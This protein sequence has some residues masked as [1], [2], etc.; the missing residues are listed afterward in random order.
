[1]T[2]G[3][4][5]NLLDK[6]SGEFKAY[7]HKDNDPAS[8]PNN[9]I[10]AL[11]VDRRGNVWVGTYLG[12]VSKMLSVPGTFE[13]YRH[14]S[15][16]S[17]TVSEL[18]VSAVYEDRKGNLWVGTWAGGLNLFNWETKKFKHYQYHKNDTT[19]INSNWIVDVFEDTRGQ[20]WVS[21]NEGCNQLDTK[22][23][24]FI[25]YKFFD[26]VKKAYI[27]FFC[28]SVAE[29][30]QGNLWLGTNL[31]LKH[32]D[33]TTKVY[34]TYSTKQGLANEVVSGLLADDKGNL[35]LTTNK[36]LSK[37][38]TRTK[39]F[40]NFSIDDGLQGSDFITHAYCKTSKGEMIFGGNNGFN[41]FHPDSIKDNAYIPP[42]FI[43]DLLI[44]NKPVSLSS[45]DSPLEK[46][47]S[48]TKELVLSYKQSVFT[49][50]FTALNYIF[51]ANNQY[52]Y[53]MEGFDKDWNY[54]GNKRAAT[55]TNL[56]PGTYTFRVKASN[57]DGLWN[58]QGT[59]IQ[60]TI[61]PPFWQ[62]WWFRCLLTFIIIGGA[63]SFYLYRIN[64]IK[65]QKVEL[66]N[67]VL[68]R[69]AEVMMQKEEL[70]AQTDFLQFINEELEEQKEEI[71]SEREAAD[72]ARQ[73][74]EQA[75]Q[76]KSIF[77]ST[78]SHEI[79]TPMNG[80]IGMASLLLETPLNTEQREYADTI[81]NCGESL[82]G[83]IN[84][85]LDFSK[86]ESGK[87]ELE[88]H[89]FD[90]R[91]CLE[92]VLDLFAA[93][94]ALIGLDLVYQM[95]HQV[96][97][98]IIGDSLRLRQIL[99]NLVGNAIKFTKQGEIFVHVES[100]PLPDSTDLELT[101]HIRDTGIGIPADKLS[102][103][104][105]A[106]SQVDSST[107]RQYGGTGL[108]LAIS[109]K[110]VALMGGHIDVASQPGQGT[111]FSFT[112]FTQASQQPTRQYVYCNL[113]GLEGKRVLIVDDNH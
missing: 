95:D 99:I 16:D 93:K 91:Q 74:A 27:P 56:D 1:G 84:D 12:A 44:F 100:Q 7:K 24:R 71:A 33:P 72:Q 69:T 23:G 108:G 111:T 68:E 32:L 54:V 75:N 46:H 96:P 58:E 101:F 4:G 97:A 31:G 79:R 77:L 82:L 86:I 59:A 20:L 29:D 2:D 64:A 61:T 109:E 78:M 63:L 81:S 15:H 51:S 26:P 102:R 19:S 39:K 49:L 18:D 42:V 83:V 50:E 43:T 112:M 70:Q 67:L 94:A 76:A 73:L 14:D 41:V 65:A 105:K 45:Q 66:E 57:N 87:M 98:Q 60:I 89:D 47:I 13:H 88:A 25:R 85:I 11:N 110:L 104:F 52:A 53:K 17:A 34:T 37:F 113:G 48:E 90:L 38:D 10:L 22:T 92:D 5:L 35:W 103:L 6:Q 3:G 107:T 21:T 80:V 36:G 62:T 55:Y 8:L 28:S 30:K 106:F 40:R 9:L